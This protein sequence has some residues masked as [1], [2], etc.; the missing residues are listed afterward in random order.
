MGGFIHL[1]THGLG[2]SYKVDS[3]ATAVIPVSGA[4]WGR[5]C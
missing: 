5:E 4:V 1:A 2:R 3:G